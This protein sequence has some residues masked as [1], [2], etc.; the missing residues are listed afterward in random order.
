LLEGSRHSLKDIKAAASNNP[1]YQNMSKVEKDQVHTQLQS[2]RNLKATAARAS[3][4]SAA[5]DVA[6]T[7]SIQEREVY[8]LFIHS[9]SNSLLT[10]WN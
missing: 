4:A 8:V 1:A 10:S 9:F 6:S 5:K 3:N 7:M 2:H